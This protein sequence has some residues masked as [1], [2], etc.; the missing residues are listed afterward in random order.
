MIKEF[1]A[2][3][4]LFRQGKELTNAATW[5]QRTVAANLLVSVLGAALLVARGFGYGIE[6]DDDTIQALAGG[7]AA[8][9]CLGN[10]VMHCISSKRAGL[11]A[12]R[13]DPAQ[14]PQTD[15]AG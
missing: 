14:Q 11:P 3:F 6:I 13:D 4:T 10:S 15:S 1:A 9:V 2:F 5:K 8:A 7:I 12:R